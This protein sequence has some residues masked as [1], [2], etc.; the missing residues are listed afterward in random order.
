MSRRFF[1]E[2]F[3]SLIPIISL[4][5]MSIASSACIIRKVAKE[6]IDAMDNMDYPNDP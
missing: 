2:Q 5:R 3:P 1:P 6:A 4:L